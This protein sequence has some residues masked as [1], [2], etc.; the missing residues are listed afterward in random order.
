MKILLV[1]EPGENGVFRHVEDLADYLISAGHTVG[2]AYSDLRGSDRLYSLL[3]RVR[4]AGGQTVNLRISNNLQLADFRALNRLWALY[5]SFKPDVVHAHSAKAGGLVRL[6]RRLGAKPKVFYTPHAYFGMGRSASLS[7]R[8][9]TAIERFLAPGT[10]TI[11]LSPEESEYGRDVLRLD[12]AQQR[13]IPN[14][15]DTRLFSPG[16]AAMKQTLRAELGI[17][18]NA[19]VL[20]SLGRFS[21]QKDPTTLHRAFRACADHLSDLYLIHVGAGELR[22]E[23]QQYVKTHGYENRVVWIEY[24]RDPAPFYRMLDGFILSSRYE[25]LSFAVLEALSTNLPLILSDAPG[26][27]SFAKLDLTHFWTARVESPA[28]FASAITSWYD[29]RLHS[30]PCNHQE[31]TLARFSRQVQFSSIEEAYA[32]AAGEQSKPPVR[33][34]LT[35]QS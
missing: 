14:G 28:S 17:P 18:A 26:N 3:Q 9:F 6:L 34:V 15:V 8:F 31:V 24:L 19:V 32:Q 35:A 30:R 16:S 2:L 7:I 13:L 4:Q 21:Y 5:R 12:P 11:N 20:G 25:G 1:S 22:S 10:V 29:A 33:S 27:G 23:L